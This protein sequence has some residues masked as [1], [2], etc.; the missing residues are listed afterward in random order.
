MPHFCLHFS[1]RWWIHIREK[2]KCILCKAKRFDQKVFC[3]YIY[4]DVCVCVCFARACKSH[5]NVCMC[6][7]KHK[8]DKDI[9][10]I[11]NWIWSFF[12]GSVFSGFLNGSLICWVL[13]VLAKKLKRCKTI[14]N[15]LQASHFSWNARHWV[16]VCSNNEQK[17]EWTIMRKQ[18]IS[19]VVKCEFGPCSLKCVERWIHLEIE[20]SLQLNNNVA[21]SLIHLIEPRN[22]FHSQKDPLI[23][24]ILS[25]IIIF[26]SISRSLSLSFFIHTWFHSVYLIFCGCCWVESLSILLSFCAFRLVCVENSILCSISTYNHTIKR[27]E[28]KKNGTQLYIYTLRLLLY[29]AHTHTQTRSYWH[30]HKRKYTNEH[31]KN[32]CR[33][34]VE[35]ECQT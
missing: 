20:S 23:L 12:S 5:S 10:I 6:T 2:K 3:I 9:A 17:E 33:R 35:C 24:S 19:W 34:N 13:I 4:V 28:R 26:F 11:F 32:C 1:Y 8:S 25:Y 15:N 29:I 21:F 18:R 14:P 16:W 22:I 30:T 7:R 31:I 27:E